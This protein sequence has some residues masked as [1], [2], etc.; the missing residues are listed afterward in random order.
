MKQ[1]E[2]DLTPDEV[3]MFEHIRSMESVYNELGFNLAIYKD[4]MLKTRNDFVDR[5]A[6]K[7]QIDNA[8]HMTYCFVTRKLKS[9][10]NSNL[11]TTKGIDKPPLFSQ[12]ANDMMV[13]SLR[14]L[15]EMLRIH[16]KGIFDGSEIDQAKAR[17]VE[18]G[19]T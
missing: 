3:K 14:T 5:V 1:F 4:A 6:K 10:F 12:A 15:M 8:N 19:K 2:F 17:G 16:K 7:Y 9:V 18:I 13:S 11:I